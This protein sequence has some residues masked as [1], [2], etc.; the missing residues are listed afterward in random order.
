LAIETKANYALI[1]PLQVRFHLP[2]WL[3][4]GEALNSLI[5]QGKL[6]LLQVGSFSVCLLV[7]I[8]AG[9]PIT[10]NLQVLP[11]EHCCGQFLSSSWHGC[12]CA[13]ACSV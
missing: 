13:Q 2:V 3:G 9:K 4:V 12:Y 11:G 10:L 7:R 5:Q 1:F 8:C 6:E